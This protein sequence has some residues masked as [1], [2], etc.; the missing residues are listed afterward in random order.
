MSEVGVNT[1]TITVHADP[2]PWARA[3]QQGRRFF[4]DPR[5][6]GAKS[7]IRFLAKNAA[8]KMA[9]RGTPVAL[10]CTFTFTHPPSSKNWN[11]VVKP[12][13]DN[14][15]K[16]VMDALTGVAWEDDVQVTTLI[17]RKYYA[18]TGCEPSTHIEVTW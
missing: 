12:D 11:H 5:V 10:T 18:E 9:P 13:L 3:R 4:T 2:V 14:L 8:V 6:A 15:V 16:L 17:A 7:M 1:F